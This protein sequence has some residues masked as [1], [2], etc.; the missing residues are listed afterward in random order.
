VLPELIATGKVL[1]PRIGWILEDTDQGPVVRAVFQG[2]PAEEAGVEAANRMVSNAFVQGFVVDY[3]R[4]DF[5]TAVNG[6]AVKSRDEVDELVS[7]A[8]AGKPI[9]FTVRRGTEG[10]EREVSIKPVLQ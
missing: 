7:Q 5:I 10:R 8:E 1:H 2:G 4:A 6:H 3:S 9:G